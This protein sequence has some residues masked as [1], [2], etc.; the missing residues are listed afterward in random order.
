MRSYREYEIILEMWEQRFNKPE[1]SQEAGIPRTTIRD[2]IRRYRSLN[3]LEAQ[4]QR[5]QKSTV[6]PILQRI[7]Q[8]DD[9]QLM[10]VY[11]LGLYLGD[12]YIALTANKR[13]YHLRI[14]LDKKYPMIIQNCKDAIQ[15]VLPKNK[16]SLVNRTGCYEVSCYYKHWPELFPQHG[17]GPRHKR[18]IELAAWQQSLVDKH[19][20]EFFRGLHHSDGSRSE[21]IVKGKNYPRYMFSNS[22]EDILKLS[23]DTCDKLNLHWTTK[24]SNRSTLAN[25]VY[26]SKRADVE[27]LDNIVGRKC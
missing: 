16:I 24:G 3:G 1:I 17:I 4:K 10:Y 9:V 26:I 15:R 8:H 14:T 22:S 11:L 13:T 20:L 19:P 23:S 2:C 6:E 12:G 7:F 18:K 25:Q 21:N 27:W 5:A